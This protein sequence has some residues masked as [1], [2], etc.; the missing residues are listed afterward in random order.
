[1]TD[2][3]LERELDRALSTG[4]G[5]EDPRLTDLVRQ[6][7]AVE[8]ELSREAP[9]GGRERALFIE[10]VG[11]RHKRFPGLK[12]LAPAVIVLGA[13]LA[14]VSLGRSALPGD[15]LYPVREA[16]A[17][18]GLA[19]SPTEEAERRIGSA[20]RALD[21]AALRVGTQPLEAQQLAFGAI[22][23]LERA[24]RLLDDVTGNEAQELLKQAS[25][26]EGRANAILARVW[27]H[28]G[29]GP[30]SSATPS[31]EATNDDNSGPGSGD[32]DNSGPGSGDDDSGPGSGDDDNSGP[33][34]GDEDNSGPG[35]GDDDDNSGPGSGNE[36][37]SGPR[38]GD[39]DNSGPGSG[40]DEDSSGPGSGD[41]GGDSSGSGSGDSSAA[42]DSSGSGSGDSSGS[43]SGDSS[44]S[45]SGD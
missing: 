17:S 16:L 41:G 18:M 15:T 44:G 10:G 21:S 37:N 35:S 32:D 36:D 39:D 11:L 6:A 8:A 22:A 9:S 25:E 23:D 13:L 3:H 26:L 12:V 33:G 42:G 1:M 24:R 19:T 14:V 27:R 2:E 34:S 4:K 40:G 31:P 7:D 38:S 29:P 45:G 43:G 5:V 30:S 28:I 20:D